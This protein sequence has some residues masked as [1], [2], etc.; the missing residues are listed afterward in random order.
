MSAITKNAWRTSSA[1]SASCERDLERVFIMSQCRK[2]R[3][4]EPSISISRLRASIPS[5]P[6]ADSGEKQLEMSLAPELIASETLILLPLESM[7]NLAGTLR[8]LRNTSASTLQ[9][10][11]QLV[12]IE[13]GI[14]Q[15]ETFLS[16]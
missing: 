12:L 5:T 6:Y 16:L 13:S 11:S 10:S 4:G 3:K 14:S 15:V 7:E 9:K 8:A 2:N 1:L